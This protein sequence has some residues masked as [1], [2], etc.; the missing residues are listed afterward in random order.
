MGAKKPLRIVFVGCGRVTQWHLSSMLKIKNVEPVA[1]CDKN[2]DLVRQVA[3]RFGIKRCY[4]DFYQMLGEEEVDIVDI[5]TPPQTHPTLSIQAIEAGCHVLVEKPMALSLRE[6]DSM[7]EA[8]Q[9]NGVRLCVVHNKLFQPVVMRAK[10]MVEKGIIGGLVGVSITDSETMLNEMILDREHW[11]H[12]LP[13]G[14]FGEMLPH[15]IYLA[16]AFMS[17]L[18]PVAVHNRKLS[19]YDWLVADELRVI[20]EAENG[21]ATITMSLNWPRENMVLDIFGTKAS[22]HV[23]IWGNVITRYAVTAGRRRFS[24]GL[25]KLGLG[26]QWLADT[27]LTTLSVISG[28]YHGGH[29]TLIQ[30][31]VESI[32]HDTEMPV[33]VEESREVVR[34]CQAITS[35]I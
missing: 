5:C 26:F 30:R 8:A 6:A 20:L 25:E 2:E 13:G 34:L 10:S 9:R 11:C 35:Q 14:I 31:F 15:P 4:T 17:R 1:V 29:Y 21:L 23:D 32:Q 28:G 19:H 24:R 27:A 33:T 22:L 18:E 7:V 16:T 12:K 3:R